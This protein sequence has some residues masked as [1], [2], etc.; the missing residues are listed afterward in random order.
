MRVLVIGDLAVVIASH[1]GRLPEAGENFLLQRP[2]IYASGVGANLAWDLRGLGFEVEVASGVGGDPLGDFILAELQQRG[3]G[4]SHVTRSADPTGMFVI[5]VDRA[6]ERTMIGFRG[7]AERFHLD[8]TVL[9][10]STPDWIHVSGYT[11]LDPAMSDRC[12]E[13][14]LEAEARGIPCSV[15]LEGIAQSGRQTE[16]DRLSVFCNLQEYRRYFGRDEV[17]P[18]ERSAPLVV[19]AREEGC[20]LVERGAVLACAAFPVTAV[21][22]TGAGDAFNAGFI[23]ARL[24]GKD[25]RQASAW[26]NAAARIKVE[27]VGPRV[28]L[29][30]AGLVRLLRGGAS[31]H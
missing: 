27:H 28:A 22:S 3:I 29:S 7:A 6:G 18:M 16:L 10:E 31:G 11:L 20:F 1:V 2:G 25:A 19:K 8:P 13:L 24:L 12:A 5:L 23:A 26:G 21:D 4:L 17:R 14:V 9:E 30:E 15:D